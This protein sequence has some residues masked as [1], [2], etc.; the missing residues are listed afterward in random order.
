MMFTG[1]GV[2]ALALAAWASTRPAA[3]PEEPRE[4]ALGRALRDPRFLGGLWLNTLLALLFGLNFVLVPLSLDEG[5]YGTLAIAGVFL[6]A[7]LFEDG[8]Q[9]ARRSLLRPPRTTAAGVAALLASVVVAVGFA[10]ARDPV[11]VSALVVL[12]AVAFGAST[13]PAMASSMTEPSRLQKK[14]NGMPIAW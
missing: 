9:P 14:K 11:V 6:A 8:G 12:A 7:G 1:V 5:G 13:C 4:A 10:V 3:Q 2:V